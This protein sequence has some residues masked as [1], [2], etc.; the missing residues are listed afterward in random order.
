MHA[1][2]IGVGLSV[3]DHI[4][5]A[6][7]AKDDVV[8]AS[9]YLTQ[10]GGLTSTAIA[11]AA[12]LGVRTEMWTRVGD[13]VNGRFVIEA[14]AGEGVDVSQIRPVDS[15]QTPVCIVKVEPSSGERDF[16]FFPGAGLAP[17]IPDLGRVDHSR[18]LLIDSHWPD[19]ARAAAERAQS[20]G[21]PV[22]TD[23]EH[24]GEILERFA[25]LTDVLV[26]PEQVGVG[27]QDSGD[28]LDA[29]RRLQEFG[30]SRVVI[31]LGDR[32]GVFCDGARTGSYEAFP[33]EVVD[34]T[35]AGDVFHGAVAYGLCQDWGFDDVLRFAAAA[36]ALN[37]RQLG[38]RAAMPTREEVEALLAASV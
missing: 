26:V 13:D 15:G 33:V 35:G 23:V 37:C 11:A 20:V 34:S 18:C 21:V 12:R 36:A 8:Y 16:I 25:A 28:F 27:Y 6:G 1:D 14:L 17:D 22:I 32:G 31:T 3:V 19:A 4:F 30:P 29:A 38:G 2:I 24:P 7:I 5:V 9:A 10:G